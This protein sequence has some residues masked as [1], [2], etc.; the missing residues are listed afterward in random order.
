MRF[1][2]T[3]DWHIGRKFNKVDLLNDQAVF[4]DWLLSVV[5]DQAIDCVL[6]AGDVFDRANPSPESVEVADSIFGRLISAN[7]QV[8]VISGNHDSAER[9]NFGSGAM[10]AAGLHIRTE[11]KS[12][13]N[14]GQPIDI[15][16]RDGRETVQVL[17][18]PYLEPLRLI[19]TLGSQRTHDAVVDTV[20]QRHR[21]QLTDPSRTIAMA[22]AWVA[23]GSASDSER[24]LSVGG[25]ST[26]PPAIFDGLGYVA[27]GHLHRPQRVSSDHIHYSGSPLAYSFTEEH[28]KIVRIID[29][30]NEITS[31]AINVEVGRPVVT[32]TDTLENL[33]H[34]S[35][36][37]ASENSF[38][39]ALLTDVSLQM[40]AMDQLRQRFPYTLDISYPSLIPQGAANVFLD[41][42]RTRKST[43]DTISEYLTETFGD[44]IDDDGKEFVFSVVNTTIAG[45][46]E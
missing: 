17:P 24:Q 20:V 23:G 29:T 33:L 45:G 12:L 46:D 2:H 11:K 5:A 31:H 16:S 15:V 26:V 8:V 44:G 41:Q 36:Y 7:V 27:L 39:R 13:I 38:V 14:V 22:H 25:S 18:I 21:S 1:L 19:D 35:Q 28:Q 34:S 30:S 42:Q 37:A 4:F 3:S 32:L 40:G 43:A 6:V 10:S 9:L